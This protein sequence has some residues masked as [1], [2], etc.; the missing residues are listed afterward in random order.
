MDGII[1]HEE[2]YWRVVALDRL[3]TSGL[4]GDYFYFIT[5]ILHGLEIWNWILRSYRFM[6]EISG[7]YD[8]VPIE[9][10]LSIMGTGVL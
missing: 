8:L 10:Y 6:L 1:Q 9:I 2:L 5:F 7:L 4:E 3:R